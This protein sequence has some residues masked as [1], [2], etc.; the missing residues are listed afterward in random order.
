MRRRSLLLAI[1]LLTT[2]F[3]AAA[4]P[5]N[6]FAAASLTDAMQDVSAA[7]ERAGHAP[8]RLSFGASS[9]LAM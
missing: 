3:A 6:V 8:L 5:V 7:W 9:T 2:P 4:Q 1:L